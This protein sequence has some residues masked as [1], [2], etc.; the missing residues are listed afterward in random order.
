[1]ASSN[2]VI[3]ST[4]RAPRAC[5]AATHAVSAVVDGTRTVARKRSA[6]VGFN[7][8]SGAP[9]TMTPCQPRCSAN[10][11]A[12]HCLRPA[13]EVVERLAQQ[14]EALEIQL[15]VLRDEGSEGREMRAGGTA[16]GDEANL[17]TN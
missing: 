3:S 1:M 17:G 8:S 5:K 7:S 6:N 16:R 2:G 11:A 9:L 14:A 10:S 12:L 13:L 4:R 15:D